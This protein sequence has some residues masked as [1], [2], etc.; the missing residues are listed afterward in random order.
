MPNAA[1]IPSAVNPSPA[2]NM[3]CARQT[4]FCGVFRSRTSRS[5]PSRSATLIFLIGANSPVC[6]DLW[7]VCQKRNTEPMSSR[8][9]VVPPEVDALEAKWW[10]EFAYLEDEIAWVHPP[11]VRRSLR[12]HYLRQIIAEIPLNGIIVDFGCG[13]GWLAILLAQLGAKRIIGVD[14]AP[15][16][17]ELAKRAA[18]QASVENVVSFEL[19]LDDAT[20]RAAD[21]VIFHRDPTSSYLA[22]IRYA[23]RRASRKTWA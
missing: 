3:I 15:A 9:D 20:C 17:I 8:M 2:R 5:N 1:A 4:T 11:E 21:V 16:Q 10:A 6:A 22:R 13:V 19:G 18:K 7:I 23:V 12:K 14:N